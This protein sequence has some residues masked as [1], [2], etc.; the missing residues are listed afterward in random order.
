[1]DKLANIKDYVKNYRK[2]KSVKLR[3]LFHIAWRNL[4]SKKLRTLLTIFGVVIGISAIFFLLSFGL[5]IQNLVTKEVIGDKSL[6]AI[7]VDSPNSKILKLDQ[8]AIDTMKKYP[9]VERIGVQYSLPGILAISGGEVDTVVYGVNRDFQSLMSLNLKEGRLLEPQDSRAIVINQS[10]LKAIG[11]E[12]KGSAINKEVKITVPLKQT[13]AKVESVKDTFTVVGVI[14]SGS[15]SEVIMPSN[16]FDGAGLPSYQQAK[17]VIDEIENVDIA[18]KQIES[19]GF[20]TSSLTDTLAEINRVFKFFNVLLVSFGSIGMIVAI[21]GMFNTLT[22]SLLERTKEI[23]LMMALG[24]RRHDMRKLFFIEAILISLAGSIIGIFLAW[25][26]GRAVNLYINMGAKGRGVN[27]SFD[28][29]STPL[30]AILSI[31]AFTIMIG[32]IVVY[33]PARRAEKID[34][35][36]ALR[37]E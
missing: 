20:K 12:G 29:F 16:I 4:M 25:L 23:G 26:A 31:I 5:G 28:L 10:A 17:V 8:A 35:I 13:G 24:A 22:I 34:P 18:R 6:K 9:H 33:L 37:R 2:Y 14:E 32:F 30:W 1:M 15:G 36:D 27:Q 3:I 21:L 7:D 11:L 19:N